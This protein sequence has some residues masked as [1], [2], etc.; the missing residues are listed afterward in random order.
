[1]GGTDSFSNCPPTLT[2]FLST[3]HSAQCTNPSADVLSWGKQKTPLA[4]SHL[5]PPP[6]PPL[7][8]LHSAALG[9]VYSVCMF[10]PSI[11]EPA[12]VSL[13]AS[14][15]AARTALPCLL[16]CCTLPSSR[17]TLSS[18]SLTFQQC[19]VP[20]TAFSWLVG[21]GLFPPSRIFPTPQ[22]LRF[23]GRLLSLPALTPWLVSYCRVAVNTSTCRWC[24]NLLRQ[25]LSPERRLH[26]AVG[27]CVRTGQEPLPVGSLIIS[28]S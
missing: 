4:H 13:A 5:P 17:S 9:R 23:P 20:E 3:D 6:P 21:P 2:A 10:L 25:N 12:P 22:Q 11:L 26:I 1:M 7:A 28:A 19:F 24:S 15:H 16:G 8:S 14:P 18:F 27:V